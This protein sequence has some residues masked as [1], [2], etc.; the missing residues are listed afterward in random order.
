MI[1]LQFVLQ[2]K[3]GGD[4]YFGYHSQWRLDKENRDVQ[5]A[6]RELRKLNGMAGEFYTYISS[7]EGEKEENEGEKER[8]DGH[9]GRMVLFGPIGDSPETRVIEQ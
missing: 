5:D 6:C 9:K 7:Y 2:S 4:T 1:Q 3:D 8:N